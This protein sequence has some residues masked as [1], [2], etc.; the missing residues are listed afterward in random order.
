MISLGKLV[1]AIMALVCV[2]EATQGLW[3]GGSLRNKT[4]YARCRLEPANND[5]GEEQTIADGVV[6][7]SHTA[8]ADDTDLPRIDARINRLKEVGT[9]MYYALG[10]ATGPTVGS[11]PCNRT[12]ADTFTRVGDFT[13][14][15]EDRRYRR[16]SL[17]GGVPSVGL[18]DGSDSAA[19]Y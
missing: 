1:V 7:V 4:L 16:F 6:I 18:I 14:L 13:P 5:A 9:D 17:V 11:T 8:N 2:A 19:W 12:D 15:F 3:Y 10:I